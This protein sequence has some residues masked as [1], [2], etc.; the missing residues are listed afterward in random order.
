[1]ARASAHVELTMHRDDN[2]L[3]QNGI[4]IDNKTKQKQTMC[5]ENVHNSYELTPERIECILNTTLSASQLLD[6]NIS[7]ASIA[8]DTAATPSATTE[9][10]KIINSRTQ[11]HQFDNNKIL[12]SQQPA[13]WS[14]VTSG[15]ECVYVCVCVQFKSFTV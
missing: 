2:R 14:R 9:R 4:L 8:V 6:D 7:Y 5:P 1:M 15:I 3:H 11:I 10:R 13:A 12:S